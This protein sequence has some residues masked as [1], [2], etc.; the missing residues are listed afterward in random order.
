MKF[1]VDFL[2]EPSAHTISGNETLVVEIQEDRS[3]FS[4]GERPT[5]PRHREGQKTLTLYLQFLCMRGISGSEKPQKDAEVHF[6]DIV[7]ALI[8]FCTKASPA[9]YGKVRVDEF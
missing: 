1:H 3:R 4:M 8:V 7:G 6:N 9:K 2:S 5:Y